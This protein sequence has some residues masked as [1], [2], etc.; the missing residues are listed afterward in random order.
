MRLVYAAALDVVREPFQGPNGE[1]QF[2]EH[3]SKPKF[4]KK[5]SVGS[6]MSAALTAHG[7]A[8]RMPCRS[9][10]ALL[11]YWARPARHWATVPTSIWSALV[12][13]RNTADYHLSRLT[14]VLSQADYREFERSR[15]N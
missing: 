1:D 13:C 3:G 7:R 8:T 11:R 14:S 9:S 4:Q 6:G 10:S 12:R 5:Q 2:D 15:A